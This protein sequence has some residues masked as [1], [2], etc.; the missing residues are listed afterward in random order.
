MSSNDT[1]ETVEAQGD[2]DVRF[3]KDVLVTAY[4]MAGYEDARSF[5]VDAFR[6]YIPEDVDMWE[7]ETEVDEEVVL[8]FDFEGTDPEWDDTKNVNK[9]ETF[10]FGR[11]KRVLKHALE[12]GDLDP[13]EVDWV[14]VR[15]EE[16]EETEYVETAMTPVSELIEAVVEKTDVPEKFGYEEADYSIYDVDLEREI[17][18]T[19]PDAEP[20]ETE[21]LSTTVNARKNDVKPRRVLAHQAEREAGNR[22][23]TP[24]DKP[25]DQLPWSVQFSISIEGTS[26]TEI[27][28]LSDA[29]VVPLYDQLSTLA[30]IRQIR[31]SDC[32]QTVVSEGECHQV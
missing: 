30:G 31:L 3:E 29:L 2:A 13:D 23:V 5:I 17:P 11:E 7:Q 9:T 12:N 27:E 6:A 24:E 26:E 16:H 14:D 4:G 22:Y 18:K 19:G 8:E 28:E 32:E 1:T 10:I 21:T 20:G 15:V 25:D